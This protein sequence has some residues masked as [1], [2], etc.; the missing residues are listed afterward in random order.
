MLQAIFRYT[1][2][3]L[4][5]KRK[6][7]MIKPKK[8]L[9]HSLSILWDFGYVISLG[10][11]WFVLCLCVS[12]R[13][14]LIVMQKICKAVT[15]INFM[16]I[17]AGTSKNFRVVNFNYFNNWTEIAKPHWND[18]ENSLCSMCNVVFC[19]IFDVCLR[20]SRSYR[21]V[22]HI[23]QQILDKIWTY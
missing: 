12:K 5:K 13:I 17:L 18:G 9:S 11:S 16:Y 4:N 7:C 10:Y 15:T 8:T 6:S 2:Q 19:N 20:F 14:N 1:Q 23:K 22:N 3:K 21:A